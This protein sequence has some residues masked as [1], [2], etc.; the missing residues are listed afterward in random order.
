MAGRDQKHRF[1]AL[2]H[3]EAGRSPTPNTP[4]LQKRSPGLTV[5]SLILKGGGWGG[6]G[7]LLRFIKLAGGGWNENPDVLTGRPE[8]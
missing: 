8:Y 2:Q 7:L 5:T 3:F 4:I 1:T 6:E